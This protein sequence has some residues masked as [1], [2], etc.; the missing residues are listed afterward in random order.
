MDSNPF[1]GL[2]DSS[3][4]AVDA[5]QK[6]PGKNIDQD[7]TRSATAPTPKTLGPREA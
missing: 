7:S 1:K 4:P 2:R 5:S 3:P 6:L